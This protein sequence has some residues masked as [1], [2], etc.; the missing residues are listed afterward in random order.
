MDTMIDTQTGPGRAGEAARARFIDHM[1]DYLEAEGLPRIAGR[2]FGLIM[3]ETDPISFGALAERLDVSRG[4]VSTNARL[5]EGMGVIAR[6]KSEG[7]RQDFFRLADQPYVNM[8]RG[9]S[10]RMARMLRTIAD[11]EEALPV[12]ARGE[13]CRLV[14]AG[15]FFETAVSA[16]GD[17]STRLSQLAAARRSS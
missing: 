6:V 1:G 14:E 12:E 2:L 9:V 5:L 13:R 4:S 3:L 16:M 10:D 15:E 8:V 17:L 11:T 7:E